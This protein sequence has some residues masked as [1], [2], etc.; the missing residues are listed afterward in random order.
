MLVAFDNLEEPPEPGI[1]RNVPPEE[2]HK[3]HACSNSQISKLL[4]SPAHL[5]AYLEDDSD[6]TS[7]QRL[8]R[9]VHAAALEPDRFD[10]KYETIGACQG[11]TNAGKQCSYNGKVLRMGE[12]YC[13]THDPLENVEYK[14]GGWYELPNGQ[15]VRG[16]ENLKE[17]KEEIKEK[18]P[19]PIS[20]KNKDICDGIRR[21]LKNNAAAD[22]LL[23]GDGDIELTI[24][25]RDPMSGVMCKGRFDRYSD[26]IPGGAIVDL[27]TTRNAEPESFKKSVFN[28]GYHRQGAMY[29]MGADAVGIDAEDFAILAVEK[30]PP[31]GVMP[32]RLSD[33][34]VRDAGETV[35]TAIQLWGDCMRTGNF[36]GYPDTVK[37]LALPAWASDEVESNKD[38]LFQYQEAVNNG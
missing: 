36:P 22:S 34:T 4:K 7:T 13:N 29:L 30:E 12:S 31:F 1:Y 27:K 10:D 8:G 32:Y 24:V 18:G 3:W 9:Q 28:Y 33:V 37:E 6:D 14:G 35:Q 5:K 25:W 11:T 2:Y 23:Y 15:C 38:K 16:K 17:F 21:S 19:D 20:E 26:E